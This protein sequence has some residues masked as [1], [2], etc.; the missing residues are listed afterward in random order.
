MAGKCLL[1]LVHLGEFALREKGSRGRLKAIVT[2]LLASP[3][4]SQFLV[5]AGG[6][7]AFVISEG[8][9]IAAVLDRMCMLSL[10]LG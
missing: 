8:M 3:F 2:L 10:V 9:K 1:K 5:Q 7:G 4:S 6:R